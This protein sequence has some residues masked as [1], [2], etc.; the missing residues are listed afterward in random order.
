MTRD[1]IILRLLA[2]SGAISR[3]DLVQDTGWGIT[4]TNAVV[5]AL[6]AAGKVVPF[7]GV[8]NNHR[9]GSSKLLCLPAVRA[10]ALHRTPEVHR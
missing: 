9:H 6:L 2:A 3:S 1:D 4:E 10:E 7:P 8:G 5:D